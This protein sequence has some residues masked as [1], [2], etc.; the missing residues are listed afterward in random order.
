M[1]VTEEGENIVKEEEKEEENMIQSVT[2]EEEEIDMMIEIDLTGIIAAAEIMKK[3]IVI[4][5]VVVITSHRQGRRY[6]YYLRY[7]GT[8]Y[9]VH[10]ESCFFFFFKTGNRTISLYGT[11]SLYPIHVKIYTPHCMFAGTATSNFPG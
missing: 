10:Y 11:I 8:W 1:I 3:I 6:A 4:Q 7:C 5:S 2:E 9:M